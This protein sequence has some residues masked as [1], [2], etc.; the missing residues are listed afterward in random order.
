MVDQCRRLGVRRDSGDFE[1]PRIYARPAHEIFKL[2]RVMQCELSSDLGILQLAHTLKLSFAVRTVSHAV[3]KY[4][5]SYY[6][7][8]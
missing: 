7:E 1:I 6:L 8:T 3:R 4:L 5:S 2:V